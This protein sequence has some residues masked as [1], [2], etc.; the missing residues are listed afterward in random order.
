LYQVN[1]KNANNVFIGLMEAETSHW[2]GNGT[3]LYPPDPWADNLQSSDPDFK[4]CPSKNAQVA[5]QHRQFKPWRMTLTHRQCRMGLY[6]IIRNSTNINLYSQGWWT[7]VM[8]PSRTLCSVDCQDNGAIYQGNSKLYVYGIGSINV[9]NLVSEDTGSGLTS[10]VT[11]AANQGSLH[12]I[13]Q[14]A[15]VAAYLKESA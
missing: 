5:F 2:Q 4:W 12:D 9:K 6:Q 8:G 1:I 11:H 13:F 3:T 7:F 10:I 14:T 15:V